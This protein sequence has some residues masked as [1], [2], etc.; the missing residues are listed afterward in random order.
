MSE[1]LSAAKHRPRKPLSEPD[2]LIPGGRGMG[3]TASLRI[4]GLRQAGGL[5]LLG[6]RLGMFGG[7]GKTPSP[8]HPFH[9]VCARLER[10]VMMDSDLSWNEEE[11][12]KDLR[13]M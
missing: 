8:S 10:G 11:A 1:R 5:A 2:P 9:P 12:Q 3:G 6:Y 13:E 7:R 4:W